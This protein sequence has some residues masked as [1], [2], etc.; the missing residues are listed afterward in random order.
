MSEIE[1]EAVE[2][3]G[4]LSSDRACG[5]ACPA[6]VVLPV[7]PVRRV[8]GNQ[9]PFAPQQNLYFSPLPQGHGA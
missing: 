1:S 9:R 6:S 7:A 4:P 5:V 8:A 2:K 3:V